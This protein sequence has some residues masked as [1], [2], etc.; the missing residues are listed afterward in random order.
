MGKSCKTS[1]KQASRHSMSQMAS[2]NARPKGGYRNKQKAAILSG[3]RAVGAPAAAYPK[4][5]NQIVVVYNPKNG[6][7]LTQSICVVTTFNQF[8]QPSNPSKS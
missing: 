3:L 6:G 7:Y 8:A 5:F 1:T 2:L 4:M